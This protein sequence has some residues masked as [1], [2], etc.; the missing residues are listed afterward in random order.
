ML[1]DENY[2]EINFCLKKE[3]CGE[4]H[5]NVLFTTEQSEEDFVMRRN[6]KTL[7]IL[8]FC[9]VYSNEEVSEILKVGT[10]TGYRHVDK[11][12]VVK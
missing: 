5:K 1:T 9:N 6:A 12:H 7:E 2:S 11:I 8:K 10:V 4:N 3:D